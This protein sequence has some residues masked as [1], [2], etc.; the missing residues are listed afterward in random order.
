MS[1]KAVLFFVFCALLSRTGLAAEEQKRADVYITLD[2][3]T[4]ANDQEL[5]NLLKAGGIAV[6]GKSEIQIHEEKNSVNLVCFDCFV[7]D[8]GDA[9]NA[10]HSY[11]ERTIK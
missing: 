7:R 4:L 10:I 11:N 3:L 9:I 1:S 6:D 5:I 8:L 2:Q